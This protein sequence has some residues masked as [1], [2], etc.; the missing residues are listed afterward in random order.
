MTFRK[1]KCNFSGPVNPCLAISRLFEWRDN[2]EN[3]YGVDRLNV[4]VII[5]QSGRPLDLVKLYE[6]L[7]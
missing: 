3:F 4:I 6:V 2:V 7:D 5:G 1:L